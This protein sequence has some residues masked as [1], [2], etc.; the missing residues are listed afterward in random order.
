MPPRRDAHG[1]FCT[2]TFLEPARRR[3]T[4]A[5]VYRRGRYRRYSGFGNSLM[6][7]QIDALD[8]NHEQVF[9]QRFTLRLCCALS[10]PIPPDRISFGVC[11]RSA[12]RCALIFRTSADRYENAESFSSR[13]SATPPPLVIPNLPVCVVCARIR[14]RPTS[15]AGTPFHLRLINMQL[16]QARGSRF[17]GA[18]FALR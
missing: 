4:P 2:S 12:G 17:R 1:E 6:A 3:V 11:T 7:V 8:I 15:E 14:T 13:N 9:Y 5:S 18:L 16:V 10:A